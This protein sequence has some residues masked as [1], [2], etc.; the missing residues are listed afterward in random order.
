MNAPSPPKMS[1]AQY[2]KYDYITLSGKREFTDMIKLSILRW[3][4]YPGVPSVIA[5][6][7]MKGGQRKI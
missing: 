6:V 2:L 7:L 5:S 4:D 3:R 1:I